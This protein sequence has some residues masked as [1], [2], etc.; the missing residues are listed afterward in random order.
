MTGHHGHR[1]AA[2]ARTGRLANAVDRALQ[3]IGIA[4]F[5][6]G[7]GHGLSP[8]APADKPESILAMARARPIPNPVRARLGLKI[9]SKMLGVAASTGGGIV[10]HRPGRGRIDVFGPLGNPLVTVKSDATGL[11]LHL[12]RDRRHLVAS[13]AES[14]M[15]ATTGGVIGVDELFAVLV[16]D[17]PFDSQRARGL[18]ASDEGVS[19]HFKMPGKNIVYAVLNPANGTP[20]SLRAM[21]SK[22]ELILSAVYGDF[23]AVG[24]QLMPKHVALELPALDLSIDVKYRSWK[25]LE[26][27]P[28]VFGLEPPEGTVSEPLEDLVRKM[29]DQFAPA[30]AAATKALPATEPGAPAAPAP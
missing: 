27:P 25:I 13:D 9:R 8:E 6:L 23:E 5:L 21:N 29:I 18:R 19:V 30:A 26:E 24:G 7:C 22:D 15:L 14:V 1:R 2:P 28:Q 16:G 12:V 20:R 3:V 4:A 11:A 10:A 17:L